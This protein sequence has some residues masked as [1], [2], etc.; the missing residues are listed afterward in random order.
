MISHKSSL[1][2]AASAEAE[3]YLLKR[4]LEF[5]SLPSSELRVGEGEAPLEIT[6]LMR[7]FPGLACSYVGGIAGQRSE[8]RTLELFFASRVPYFFRVLSIV[9]VAFHRKAARDEKR[10]GKQRRSRTD[11]LKNRVINIYIGEVK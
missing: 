4:G 7:I 9:E 5:P 10:Y 6:C 11:E 1:E 8:N 3:I 2:K